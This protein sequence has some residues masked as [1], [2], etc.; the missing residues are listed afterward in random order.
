M[1][2]EYRR[3]IK[4]KSTKNHKVH[5]LKFREYQSS[6]KCFTLLKITT[7]QNAKHAEENEL[8]NR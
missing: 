4:I 3:D 8:A 1:C 7:R 2:I 6:V 5:D